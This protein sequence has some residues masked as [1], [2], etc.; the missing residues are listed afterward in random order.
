ML[1]TTATRLRHHTPFP[2]L[3][4]SKKLWPRCCDVRYVGA[5]QVSNLAILIGET[6]LTGALTPSH[7]VLFPPESGSGNV[8]WGFHYL[9]DPGPLFLASPY[10]REVSWLRKDV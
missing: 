6:I 3:P 7:A 5:D 2:Y 4:D 9:Y 10:C 1:D 8:R